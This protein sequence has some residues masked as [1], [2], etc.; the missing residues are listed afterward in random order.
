MDAGLDSGPWEWVRPAGAPGE[1]RGESASTGQ[2]RPD[3]EF[4]AFHREASLAETLTQ[5]QVFEPLLGPSAPRDTESCPPSP[6]KGVLS[7]S[8]HTLSGH[9]DPRLSLSL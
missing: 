6:Q 3:L 7:C 5:D 1:F 9:S 4:D 8:L 2:A